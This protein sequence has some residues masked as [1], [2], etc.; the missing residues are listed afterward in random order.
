MIV[1]LAL[2][3]VVPLLLLV[4][5][6]VLWAVFTSRWVRKTFFCPFKKHRIPR[7]PFI[8]SVYAM[9]VCLD[10]K[11]QVRYRQINRRQY[12]P[13]APPEPDVQEMLRETRQEQEAK[14][15]RDAKILEEAYF[16]NALFDEAQR[17]RFAVT[18]RS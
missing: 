15:L 1:N 8:S 10:C 16:D 17:K 4:T 5:W 6:A 7:D 2:V 14:E 11:R 13:N 3:F 18:N 9:D 12:F